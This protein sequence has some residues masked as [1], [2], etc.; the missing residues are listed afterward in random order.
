ML[1]SITPKRAALMWGASV[2]YNFCL[3]VG[4]LLI[5]DK[6]RQWRGR[7]PALAAGLTDHVW[8]S[9]ERF[10]RPATQP[11]SDAPG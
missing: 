9:R 1:R 3:R 10:N 4:T 6:D 7:T 5:K 2:C 8:T 11:S